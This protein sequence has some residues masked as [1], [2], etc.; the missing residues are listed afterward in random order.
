MLNEHD[1]VAENTYPAA[2]QVQEAPKV[3]EAAAAKEAQK[4]KSHLALRQRAEAAERRAQDLERMIQMNMSQNQQTT[5]MQIAE[6]EDDFNIGDDSYVEGKDLKK[7]LRSLKKEVRDAKKQLEENQRENAISSAEIKL[8]T[9]Y[10]D[11]D[12]VVTTDNLRKLEET[13]PELFRTIYANTNIADRGIAAYE[14]I[15]AGGILSEGYQEVDRRLEENKSKP[16]AAANAAPQS[17]DTPLA[18]VGDYDRRILSE[19]RKE[20]LRRQVEEAKRYR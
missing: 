13:K 11:F 5:K 18:R 10:A 7:Y 3:D 4:E 15:K 12:S 16:R 6:E 9:R 8:K 19:E 17:G 20:Q 1:I 2:E 14:M